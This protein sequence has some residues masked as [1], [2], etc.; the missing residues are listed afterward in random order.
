MIKIALEALDIHSQ[1]WIV[2]F[3][4]KAQQTDFYLV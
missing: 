4:M 2:I 1:S 3:L